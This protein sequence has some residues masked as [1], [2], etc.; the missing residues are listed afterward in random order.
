MNL[1]QYEFRED[2]K[3]LRVDERFE[4]LDFLWYAGFAMAQILWVIFI[5]RFFY[6]NGLKQDLIGV[7]YETAAAFKKESSN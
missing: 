5:V 3:E 1:S 7:T 2:F 6:A 4:I